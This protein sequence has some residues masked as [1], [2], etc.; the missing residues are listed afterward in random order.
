MR[1]GAFADC[2]NG[3]AVSFFMFAVTMAHRPHPPWREAESA[4]QVSTFGAQQQ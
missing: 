1:Y 2:P 3:R 4:Q